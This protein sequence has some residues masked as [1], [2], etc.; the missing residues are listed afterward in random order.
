MEILSQDELHMVS[1]GVC[2]PLQVFFTGGAMLTAGYFAVQDYINEE[3]PFWKIPFLMVAVGSITFLGIQL[4]ES[5][6][7]GG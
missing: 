7:P 5:S 6:G 1:A 4:L 3:I 2:L